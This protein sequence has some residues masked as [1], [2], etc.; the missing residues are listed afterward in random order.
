VLRLLERRERPPKS[1]VQQQRVTR[2]ELDQVAQ[3]S[4][5]AAAIVDRIRGLM[6]Y[7]TVDLGHGV[8]TPGF[9]DHRAQLPYYGLPASMAGMR[10]LDIAT[11][12]GF[13][14]YE[15]E[16]R[17]ATD[18]TA[19]DVAR[20]TD[21]DCPRY[22]LRDPDAFNLDR[23]LGGSFKVA[24]DILSSKVQRVVRSVYDLDPAVDGMFDFVFISDVLIHL[25][26][27]QLALERAY[28]VC[29]G[30]LI[31]A[32]VY[33]P[34]LEGLGDVPVAQFLG[35]GETW[36]FPNV[37]CLRQMMTVAGFEPIEEVSR[38]V[39]DATG[40]NHIH[41]V[42]LRGTANPNPTW[43]TKERAARAAASG[44]RGQT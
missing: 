39:L 22:M 24:H 10:C 9:V 33:S 16:N 1:A 27:P 42:V 5:E 34:E 36:W 23:E 7:H 8:R 3:S 18:V 4:P 17:G 25:R 11:F 21:I 40:T 38:F 35:P 2:E 12:D 15:F 32:D 41:K 29:R 26:D 6:W 28:S 19:I 20:A 13:W 44:V 37:A 43:A 31:V 14:A 30:A